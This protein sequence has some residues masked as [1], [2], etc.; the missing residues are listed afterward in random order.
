MAGS[1]FLF[2]ATQFDRRLIPYVHV[3]GLDWGHSL[4]DNG[5]PA[6]KHHVRVPRRLRVV[7]MW[8]DWTTFSTL[9]VGVGSSTRP[10]RFAIVAD[11]G[12]GEN[13]SD[14]IAHLLQLAER[15]EIDFVLHPGDVGYSDGDQHWW[16][17]FGRKIEPISSQVPYHVGIGNH[18]AIWRNGTA[19]KAR[20]WMP[21]P[22][23]GAP[24]DGTY[25]QLLFGSHIQITMLNSESPDDVPFFDQSQL[26]WARKVLGSRAN[27]VFKLVL[28]HRPVYCSGY[29]VSDCAH[30]GNSEI[31]RSFV[32]EIYSQAGVNAVVSG[33]VHNYERTLPVQNWTVASKSND[34]AGAPVY[35]VNGGAGNREGQAEFA[36]TN[37]TWSAFR[38][39]E[40]GFIIA[41]ITASGPSAV[42]LT[43]VFVRSRDGAVL[44]TFNVTTGG[45]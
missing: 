27:S 44:D 45:K 14:T 24:A 41:N 8:S 36:F 21:S 35:F 37:R 10:L 39:S 28:H 30:T 33:H 34:R 38:S 25:Y 31:M 17:L 16:D 26:N 5:Q 40:R 3:R 9:P 15:R 42:S 1:G 23:N 19:Y 20:W 32:E 18:E 11:M 22:G 43:G 13:S 7:L 12:W 4:C 6:P 29:S 2:R